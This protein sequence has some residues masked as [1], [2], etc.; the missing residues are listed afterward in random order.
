MKNTNENVE[1]V[2][3]AT[4]EQVSMWKNLHRK[5]FQ[6]KA[7]GS[8]GYFKK[9]SRQVLAAAQAAV[10]QPIRFAEIIIENC[11]IGGDESIK[12]DDE[13]FLSVSQ[14]CATL[15]EIEESSIKEL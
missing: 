1:L 5:V 14:Q 10:D 4:E 12:T 6:I 11:F 13:K 8:V 3:Q 7:C 2:G 15:L 9:P